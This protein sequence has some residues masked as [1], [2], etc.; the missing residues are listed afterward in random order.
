MRAA[1]PPPASWPSRE[2]GVMTDKEQTNWVSLDELDPF[3]ANMNKIVTTLDLKLKT[4]FINIANLQ[5][6]QDLF[7]VKFHTVYPLMNDFAE[8]AVVSKK[9]FNQLSAEDLQNDNYIIVSPNK[10]TLHTANYKT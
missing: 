5:M 7:L 9:E 3:I 10:V 4:E 6:I 2:D 1:G 8:T